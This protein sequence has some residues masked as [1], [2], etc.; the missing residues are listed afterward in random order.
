MAINPNIYEGDKRKKVTVALE[1]VIP[2]GLSDEDQNSYV[3]AVMSKI[4][5]M[6]NIFYKLESSGKERSVHSNDIINPQ[7][8]YVTSE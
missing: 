7:W 3:D 4:I 8:E 6:G 5:S 1:V 2:S